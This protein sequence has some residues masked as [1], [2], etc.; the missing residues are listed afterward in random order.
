MSRSLFEK[1][2]DGGRIPLCGTLMM[3]VPDKDGKLFTSAPTK[4]SSVQKEL[5][6]Y[7]L[8]VKPHQG[9][10]SRQIF[11]EKLKTFP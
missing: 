3:D 9:H 8:L 5:L 6:G 2:A 7:L 10:Y 11:Y 4:S 1:V